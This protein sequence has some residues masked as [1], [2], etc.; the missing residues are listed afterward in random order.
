MHKYSK[1]QKTVLWIIFALFALY[2]FTLLYPFLWAGL[3]SF[4]NMDDYTYNVNGI[5]KLGWHFD[6]YQKA[7]DLMK[8]GSVGFFGM[9]GNSI[10]YTLLGTLFQVFSASLSAYIVAKYDFKLRNFIYGLALFV[11]IIPT[12]GSLPAQ[13]RLIH[14][15]HLNNIVGLAIAGASG[16]G[17][18][19]I[20]LYAYFK[21]ISWEYAEAATID[22]AND[23]TIFIKIM[24]P[25]AKPALAAMFITGAVGKWNDY[26]TP[27]LYLGQQTP[28]LSFAIYD[29]KLRVADR[30]TPIF[31]AANLLVT[32]P[33]V[34]GFSIFSKTIIENTV[35]G[36]LKG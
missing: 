7:L 35:A 3:N 13:Y 20:L 29:L 28:V 22:G 12:I 34:L 30:R 27:L 8:I 17:T 4:K 10:T 32:L 5:P 24:L 25:Q 21:A 6:N 36:G 19:F 11:M 18:N 16:F 15:L 1:T 26:M 9:F 2:S 23:W 33:V 14:D 31:L